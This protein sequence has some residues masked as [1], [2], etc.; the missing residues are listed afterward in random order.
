MEELRDEMSHLPLSELREMQ[1]KLGLKAF[2]KLRHGLA[3]SK[4]KPK[5]FKRENKNRPQEVSA[6]KPVSKK[7]SL[8]KEKTI[9][10]P[11]FDDLSGEFNEDIFK[12]TYGFLSDV[13]LK[14]KTK[15]KKMIDST[16][17]KE[18][19]VEMKSLLNRMQQQEQAGSAGGTDTAR[20]LNLT[21]G[22]AAQ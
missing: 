11:R 3:L 16:K 21:S 20:A 10:D 15:L 8:A 9:R 5:V 18:K 13:K 7:V 4:Q 14:E 12:D 1:E 22:A 2:N 19:K 6:R 17:D